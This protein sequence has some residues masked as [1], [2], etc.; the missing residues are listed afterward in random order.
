L[1]EASNRLK[2]S[3]DPP[4]AVLI[5]HRVTTLREDSQLLAV[6]PDNFR[7]HLRYLKANFPLLRF[8]DDWSSLA[9][10]SVVIT[11]DDGYADNALEALP[12]IEEVGVP[13]T[14]FISTG[15]LGALREFW[16]DDL[17]RIILSCGLFPAS[18]TLTDGK[19]NRSWPTAVPAERMVLYEDLHRLMKKIGPE[20]RDLWIS[21]LHDW[22]GTDAEGR[23]THRPLTN[24][25]LQSL[26]ANSRVTIGAHTVSHTP[27][28]TLSRLRQQEE[29]AESRMF[30][31]KLL[32]K[33]IT[34]FSYP[35]GGKCD[36]TDIS[37]NLCREA[38]FIKAA[39]NFP[40][41]A[42]RWTNPYH[43]PRRLVRNWPLDLF[44][45]KMARFWIS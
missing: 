40:G 9:E 23:E 2:N 28:A 41:L 39:A 16:W 8:E 30:L 43:I 37:A 10:P 3:F 32:G 33:E 18:F 45:E 31:E 12:I 24:N 20:R 17:E 36:Y 13:A 5:Y 38:G 29:I 15:T 6:S 7:D 14:F 25:E 21:Q 42:H 26:S 1:L 11:F 19:L 27:L 44:A 4:V 22:A 35:F 34:V